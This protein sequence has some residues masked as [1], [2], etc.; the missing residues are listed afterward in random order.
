M[1][2]SRRRLIPPHLRH[3]VGGMS[4]YGYSIGRVPGIVQDDEG[5]QGSDD[6]GQG[7]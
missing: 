4:T 7:G 1:L 2:L 6:E 3:R 5:E